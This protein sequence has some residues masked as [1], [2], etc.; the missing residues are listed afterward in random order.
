VPATTVV[1]S[2]EIATE[3]MYSVGV[4]IGDCFQLGLNDAALFLVFAFF[5][6]DVGIDFL[7]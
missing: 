3:L 6:F 2:C 5:F 4:E 7:L 1:P